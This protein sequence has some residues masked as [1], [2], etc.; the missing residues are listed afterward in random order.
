[1]IAKICFE[2]NIPTISSSEDFRELCGDVLLSRLDRLSEQT[3]A[4]E[5]SPSELLTKILDRL[6]RVPQI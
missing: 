3:D 2:H 5:S 6:E 1:M 4:S